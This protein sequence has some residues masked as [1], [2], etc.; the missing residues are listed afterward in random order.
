MSEGFENIFIKYQF[1]KSFSR[2]NRIER[3]RRV[4]K[5]CCKRERER[6]KKN[7]TRQPSDSFETTTDFKGTKSLVKSSF[8][9]S[10]SSNGANAGISESK[11]DLVSVEAADTNKPSFS[12]NSWSRRT[13]LERLLLCI[14]GILVLL[15]VVM[16]ILSIVRNERPLGPYPQPPAPIPHSKCTTPDCIASAHSLLQNMNPEVDPCDDFYQFACGGFEARS[17]IADDK[18]YKSQFSIIGDELDEQIRDI[19]ESNGTEND[20]LV[21]NQVRSIYQACMNEDS[22][23]GLGLE[24]ML[25]ELK[26][27][28]GWPVLDSNWKEEDFDWKE[29]IY[30]FRASGHGTGFLLSYFI[31]TDMKNSTYRV[32]GFDQ[33]SLGLSREYLVQGFE[34]ENV[35]YYYSYM[36][37]VAVLLEER[38][39]ASKLYNPMKLIDVDDLMP[40]VNFTDYVNGILTKDIIQV[41]GNERVIVGTPIFI[42]R[43][44]TILNEEP[45]RNVA[46]Y[47]LWRIA[48]QGL[49]VLNKAAREISL[50]YRKNVTGTPADAPRWKKSVWEDAKHNM[51]EMVKYIKKEFKKILQ[52]I[53]WM[54]EQTRTRAINKL[55]AIKEYIAY[56]EEIM[57]VEN[58]EELYKGLKINNNTYFENEKSLSLWSYSYLWKKLR[59]KID[60]TDWKRHAEPAVVNAFYSSIE[61]SIQFPAGILQGVFF[62]KNRP[63]YMNYGSIGWVIGHEITH[64][65]DD[66]GR[67]SDSNGNL[68]DWW[69]ME[70]KK[71][72]LEK[73]QCIIWQYGNYTSKAVNVSLNGVNTQ[74]ENIADNGGLKEAYRAYVSWES[75][76][77]QENSLP[78]LNF[79]SRQLFWLSAANNWCSK[80]RPKV[81]KNRILTGYHSPGAFRVRGTF[82]NLKEFSQDFKCPLGTN[83]NPINKCEVW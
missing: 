63:H 12:I 51:M 6:E 81:L 42:K 69:E 21:F 7:K 53:T 56:P 39:N 60:K 47:L 78:G 19:L 2:K 13:S 37:K 49:F 70:T 44:S 50:E 24:P 16:I 43:L 20:S 45:K 25:K 34:S 33:A 17:R 76:H 82:S 55:A 4:K 77:G 15:I 79:N 27:L 72:F 11:A 58:L 26:S 23:E 68:N 48:S 57:K 80:F 36:Q 28:G 67:Q 31:T 62:N 73:A 52:E 71:K 1:L 74:G 65:F 41:D 14:C 66:R 61:N 40:G 8:E 18:T 3:K 5:T 10:G 75:V 64:G 22:L 9:M 54:D 29:T 59:E 83:M 30:K 38:R 32:M 35:N 46:N